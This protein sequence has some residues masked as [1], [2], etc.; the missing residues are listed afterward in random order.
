MS[1]VRSQLR[2]LSTNQRER[3]LARLREIRPPEEQR[4]GPDFSRRR[5]ASGMLSF[6]QQRLWFLHQMY[7]E[8]TAYHCPLT[9]RINLAVDVGILERTLMEISRRHEILRTKFELQEGQ[10][11]QSVA[12]PAAVTLRTMDLRDLAESER[13]SAATSAIREEFSRP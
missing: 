7:P 4:T 9:I 8:T 11:I 1:D 10:P 6:A 3:L 12:P 5:A 2:D 13:E